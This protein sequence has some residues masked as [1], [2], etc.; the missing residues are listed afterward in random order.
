METWQSVKPNTACGTGVVSLSK[1]C[2]RVYILLFWNLRAR[3]NVCAFQT[4]GTVGLTL[5]SFTPISSL[6][7]TA[8]IGSLL[9]Q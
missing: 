5:I 9:F 1:S 7:N 3:I 6:V 4:E 8:S 2:G